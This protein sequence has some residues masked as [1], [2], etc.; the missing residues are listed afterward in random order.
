V[1]LARSGI[2][3]SLSADDQASVRSLTRAPIDKPR[4]ARATD[5]LRTHSETV[6]AAGY[7]PSHLLSM[8]R[9]SLVFL[10]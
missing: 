5:A 10:K 9:V 7:F 3:H 8:M 4:I 6:S 2:N 1:W